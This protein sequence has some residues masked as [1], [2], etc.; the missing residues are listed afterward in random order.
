M[1][2]STVSPTPPSETSQRPELSVVVLCYQTGEVA[3]PFTAQLKKELEEAG[4]DYEMVLV[5]N[6]VP[7]SGD[8]TPEILHALAEENPRYKVVAKAKEGAMGWDMRSGLE[9]ASGEHL[10]VIDGDGQMPT[11]D[12]VKV[13]RMLQIGKYDLVKT[14]RS[15][16]Y[17]GVYRRIITRVYNFIF[18]LMFRPG[19]RIIDVN[20]KPKV[21]TRAAFEHM[22]L[23]SSD[24]FTDAEIM[25]EALSLRLRVGEISTVFLKNERRTSFVPPAAILEFLKNLVYYRLKRFKRKGGGSG[26]PRL[27][28][29]SEA[30]MT[31]SP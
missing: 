18:H 20:A 24:W 12:I 6:Y 21:M 30:G 7:G 23:V 26:R 3:Q 19:A 16:R 14:F 2:A 1:S 9:A 25:I 13:Y 8:K 29:D 28:G 11:S 22:H 5:G 15:K 10:C 4:I 31:A 27:G 17:D